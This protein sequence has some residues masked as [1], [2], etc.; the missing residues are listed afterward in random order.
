[1]IDMAEIKPG[2]NVPIDHLLDD[3]MAARKQEIENW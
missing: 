3:L 2:Y 1:M